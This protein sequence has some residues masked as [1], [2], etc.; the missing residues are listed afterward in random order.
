[1]RQVAALPGVDGI[2]AASTD[3]GSF[4]GY[5]QGDPEYEALVDEIVDAAQ[6]EGIWL[7]GPQAWMNRPAF[8][9]FQAPSDTALLS[10]GIETS[11]ANAPTGVAPIEGEED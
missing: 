9:I 3:L 7:G 5:R 2:F 8:S 6:D 1:V 11:L 4:S 10:L